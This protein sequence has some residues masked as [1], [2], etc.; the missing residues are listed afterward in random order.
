MVL[1][2]CGFFIG[3][4]VVGLEVFF[5]VLFVCFGE[6]RGLGLWGRVLVDRCF[7]GFGVF[8]MVEGGR[9]WLRGVIF[10]MRVRRVLI[11]MCF[12]RSIGLLVS[13]GCCCLCFCWWLLLFVWFLLLLFLVRGIFLDI[14]L[15]WV[16]CFWC[17]WCL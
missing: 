9:C 4:G 8:L 5:L 2:L 10:L 16:W 7:L 6:D 17:W 13:M 3:Y 12:M 1:E 11:K 14:R 15:F